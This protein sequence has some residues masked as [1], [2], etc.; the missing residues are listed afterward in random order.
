[1]SFGMASTCCYCPWNC[2][3]LIKSLY[4]NSALAVAWHRPAAIG[5]SSQLE[6]QRVAPVGYNG[7][8]SDE[9]EAAVAACDQGYLCDVC[10]Q[11]VA[12]ITDSDLYLRYV[13]G[14]VPPLGAADFART[15]YP[16]QPGDR[17]VH[18]RFGF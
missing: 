17:T 7:I 14:E 1:M 4:G 18:C 9:E 13:M 5:S 15:P 3:L 8:C 6:L 11:D 12:A 16:L 10:G 2:F